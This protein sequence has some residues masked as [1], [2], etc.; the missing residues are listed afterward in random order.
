MTKWIKNNPLPSAF[1]IA[2]IAI[3]LLLGIRAGVTYLEE[4][5]HY[6]SLE[7]VGGLRDRQETVGIIYH[8]TAAS[9][10]P[11]TRH[12]EWH[13]FR[14]WTMVGYHYHIRTDGTIEAGRPH[15]VWG[16]H[17]KGENHRT[18]GIAFSG[19]LDKYPPTQEQYDSAIKLQWWLEEWEEY[20]ELE[21]SGHNDW[22]PTSCPGKYMD[23]N[24]I[25]AG[26]AVLREGSEP[27]VGRRTV[28]IEP[29]TGHVGDI[30]VDGYLI[31]EEERTYV[32]LRVIAEE[33]GYEVGWDPVKREWSINKKGE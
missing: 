27:D 20:G 26:V 6:F 25:R 15:H 1:I 2:A 22:A 21:I 18:I 16:A 33:L 13:L 17:V 31:I 9:D 5:I 30:T 28:E 32:P 4:E 29:I 23:L 10:R 8:H 24:I 14:G 7:P 12:H 19:D 11:I 3:T